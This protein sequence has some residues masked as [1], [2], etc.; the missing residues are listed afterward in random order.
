[1]EI[2]TLAT[3]EGVEE[4]G[5]SWEEPYWAY[6]LPTSCTVLMSALSMYDTVL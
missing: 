4:P 3:A 6:G 1:M 5:M 2:T